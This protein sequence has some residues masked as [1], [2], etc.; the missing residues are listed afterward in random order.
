MTTRAGGAGVVEGGGTA[1]RVARLGAHA[2]TQRS[3]ASTSSD[4]A[5]ARPAARTRPDYDADAAPVVAR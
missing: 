3:P 1:P 5:G 4:H 2:R